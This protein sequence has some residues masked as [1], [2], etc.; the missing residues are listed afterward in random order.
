MNTRQ[1]NNVP[2]DAEKRD[3]V[4]EMLCPDPPCLARSL[5]ARYGKDSLLIARRWSQIACQAGDIDRE[6]AWKRVVH[7]VGCMCS[8]NKARSG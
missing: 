1:K 4:G 6:V 8:G 2:A 5:F 3:E 7:L